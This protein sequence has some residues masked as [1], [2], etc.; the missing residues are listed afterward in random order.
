MHSVSNLDF[1]KDLV[2][3]EPRKGET[4]KGKRAAQSLNDEEESAE[5]KIKM[6]HCRLR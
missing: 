4:G 3:S 6:Y 5:K 1:L 2:S